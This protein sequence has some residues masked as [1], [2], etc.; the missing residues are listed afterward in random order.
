M[1][2]CYESI[3]YTSQRCFHVI[4]VT[5]KTTDSEW[6]KL[7]PRKIREHPISW[8]VL[9]K[10][11][12]TAQGN[13]DRGAPNLVVCAVDENTVMRSEEKESRITAKMK[14]AKPAFEGCQNIYQQVMQGCPSEHSS[15]YRV[16][17][18]Q[19]QCKKLHNGCST[20]WAAAFK[21]G[22]L[23]VKTIGKINRTWLS[24]KLI[25]RQ[26]F[27]NCKA[28]IIKLIIGWSLDDLCSTIGGLLCYVI[29]SKFSRLN[30]VR[31][32]RVFRVILI[33]CEPKNWSWKLWRTWN[34]TWPAF[35]AKWLGG[36][37]FF[38]PWWQTTTCKKP[39]SKTAN[40][41]TH[42][43]NLHAHSQTLPPTNAHAF[44]G[45][46]ARTHTRTHPHTHTLSLSN[47]HTHARTR[48]CTQTTHTH[49]HTDKHTRR[50]LCTCTYAR[51][52]K[53]THTHSK[54]IV[55]RGWISSGSHCWW[56][57][58]SLKQRQ[59][60]SVDQMEDVFF[61]THTHTH[62]RP[63]MNNTEHTDCTDIPPNYFALTITC[64]VL[65]GFVLCHFFLTR[66]SGDKKKKTT[67]MRKLS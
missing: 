28:Q 12:Q 22:K 64:V 5:W 17:F 67:R 16:K 27:P 3:S 50:H 2:E 19:M 21:R 49:M 63:E 35:I 9:L 36:E 48:T 24:V 32:P 46:R 59:I 11:S 8:N 55:F 54:A 13:I 37:G 23:G 60:W 15:I 43:S 51:T 45:V 20:I 39:W 57:P 62:T 33:F 44:P 53:N 66:C 47:T 65:P 26:K 1:N 4:R 41:D 61:D 56:W 42:R 29:F 25:V 34:Y 40:F 52:H 38:Y 10:E 30:K 6:L 58:A 14:R 18:V 31:F 7:K